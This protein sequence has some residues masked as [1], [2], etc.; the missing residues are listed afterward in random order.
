MT[1]YFNGN[2]FYALRGFDFEL[3]KHPLDVLVVVCL[4]VDSLLGVL[5]AL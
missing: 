5:L 1:D 3:V 4:A 2:D